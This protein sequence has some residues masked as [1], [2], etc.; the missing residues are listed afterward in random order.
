VTTSLTDL[1]GDLGTFASEVWGRQPLHRRTD[2]EH[3]DLLDVESAELLLLSSARRPTFRLVQDGERLPPER[4]TSPTRLGG[5][6]LDDV[7]DVT[8]IAAAVD[9]G[10]TLV[11]QG[12]QR[13]WP[14][15]IELCRSLERELS[16]PVQANAYL[17][18]A[19]ASGLARHHDE[20]D[21]LVLQVS[22]RKVWD[23]AGLGEV[24]MA[25]GDVLYLPAGTDHSASAQEVPSL[26]LT[27]GILR[28][29]YA[30]VVRRL[31]TRL[32]GD[33]LDGPLP[34]GFA[35]PDR[36]GALEQDLA[37]HL[38]LAAQALAG[39]DV[40]DVARREQERALRWRAPLPAGQLRSVLHLDQLGADTVVVRRDDHDA[41]LDDEPADDGRLV[42][43][44]RDRTLH[45]PAP[46]RPALE[47][48]LDGDE[49]K[50]G[51]LPGLSDASRVV[52]VRRLVR[53]G[54]LVVVRA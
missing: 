16:H 28:I 51:E 27:L 5:T 25:P 13:T 49:T 32:E 36:T 11:L 1:V 8:K 47:Q 34:L 17:T 15:L 53:E 9:G 41:V 4:S 38:T 45:I 40:V 26:H 7:A 19:G 30:Q 12:L 2:L 37:A 54:L 24:V 20:H 48:L 22:G 31:L 39:T 10:A 33:P 35:H 42:L 21:V 50:V 18:P 23:V 3:G 46:A 43:R 44:L 14:P 52:L 6:T 29:T